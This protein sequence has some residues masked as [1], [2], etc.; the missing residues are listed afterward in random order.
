M[1]KPKKPKVE[2]KAPEKK[3]VKKTSKGKTLGPILKNT[4]PVP[5]KKTKPTEEVIEEALIDGL[6]VKNIEF[7][8]TW[9][10]CYNGT[11]AYLAVYP[12]VTE[13]TAAVQ[14]SLLMNN[15]KVVTYLSKRIKASIEKTEEASGKLLE[16]YILMA[17]GDANELVEHRREC[18]RHCYGTN[19]LYQFTPQ[20][21]RDRVANWKKELADAEK[22]GKTLEPLDPLGGVG[23]N[24]RMPPHPDCPE[25]SGDGH[26]YVHFHDTRRLSRAATLMYAGAKIG[27][28]G[29]EVKINSREKA[30]EVLARVFKLVEDK[31]VNNFN[32]TKDDLD[33]KFGE[34]MALAS[35]RQQSIDESRGIVKE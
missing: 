35:S 18:C 28:D 27:R 30:M 25:C 22:D 3:P 24:R 34:S 21:Q 8:E 19:F 13:H 15:P 17:Y 14:S 9:L 5:P 32:F 23:Y 20:E 16:S 11:K 33:A 4:K 6:T 10:S 29:M 2:P 26:G 12:N 7:V 1:S 31:T